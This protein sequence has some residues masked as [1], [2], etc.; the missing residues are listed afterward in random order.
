MKM[1][2]Q[3]KTKGNKYIRQQNR[4]VTEKASLMSD[5]VNDL[6]VYFYL[7]LI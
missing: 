2:E 5:L 6:F 3:V 4:K 7:D 1:K